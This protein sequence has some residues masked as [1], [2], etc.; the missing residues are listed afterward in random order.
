MLTTRLAFECEVVGCLSEYQAE[1]TG[2]DAVTLRVVPAPGFTTG[3]VEALR[4][5]LGRLVGPG[6]AVSVEIVDRIPWEASGKRPLIKT[7]KSSAGDPAPLAARTG[8]DPGRPA[9]PG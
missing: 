5:G 3:I 4:E 8:A 1:Q 2:P 7:H 6:V 9:A